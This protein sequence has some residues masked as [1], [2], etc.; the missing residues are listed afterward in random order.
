LQPLFTA[1]S[2]VLKT[3]FPRKKILAGKTAD[4]GSEVF[5]LIGNLLFSN[6]FKD[7]FEKK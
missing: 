7:F 2:A 1:F 3:N 6:E 5:K 4:V